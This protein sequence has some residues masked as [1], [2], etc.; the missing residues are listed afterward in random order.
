MEKFWGLVLKVFKMGSNTKLNLSSL[1]TYYLTELVRQFM[2]DNF[3]SK[4]TNSPK[5]FNQQTITDPGIP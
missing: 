4:G 1:N 5:L 3:V 2:F